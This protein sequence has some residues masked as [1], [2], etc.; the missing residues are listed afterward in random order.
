M[1]LLVVIDIDGTVAHA[2]RRFETAG[3]EPSRDN[4]EIYTTWVNKVQDEASLLSDELVP[5]M[6][7]L[8]AALS[9]GP[10]V[11]YL[12]SREEK[13]RAAT[14]TWLRQKDLPTTPLYL[15]SN[16]DW[17]DTA[18]FKE[19]IIGLY[20]VDKDITEV[21]VIDDDEHGTIESMCKKNGYTFLKAR[22]GGQK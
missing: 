20:A 17:R 3:P 21:I 12:S 14:Q 4:R 11:I 19:E 15:R 16:G 5:G 10:H 7:S 8:I 9:K 18:Q 22:S 13:W 2:G 1:S 6:G